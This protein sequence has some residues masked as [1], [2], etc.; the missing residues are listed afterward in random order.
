MLLAESHDFFADL[1]ESGIV[2]LSLHAAVDDAGHFAGIFFVEATSRDSGSTETDTGRIHRL[3]RI[4]RNRRTAAGDADLFH[5]H[6]SFLTGNTLRSHVHHDEVVVGAIADDLVAEL[7]HFGAHS[8]SVLDH[9]LG[10]GL[11]FRLQSFEEC[12]G[13]TGVDVVMRTTL[14]TREHALVDF[15][16]QRNFLEFALDHLLD[17]AV[18][19]HDDSRTRTTESLVGGG[20][21]D[22]EVRHRRI[23]CLTCDEASDVRNVSHGESA[24]FVGDFLE[25]LPVEVTAVGGETGEDHLRLFAESDF[26]DLVHVDATCF[27]VDFVLHE[28]VKHTGEV[29]R[30]AVRKVSTVVELEAEDLVTRLENGE[31]HSSVGRRTGKRLDIHV[32]ATKELLATFDSEGFHLVDDFV[33]TIVTLA[34]VAFTVLVGQHGAHGFHDGLGGVVFGS[35]ELDAVFLAFGFFLNDVVDFRICLLQCRFEHLATP[36]Y[37]V[38]PKYRIFYIVSVMPIILFVVFLASIAVFAQ[39]TPGAFKIDSIQYTIG[40]AF[41]DSRYH[42]KYDKWALDLLNWIHIETR[43]S[44]V[45]KLLLFNEGETVTETQIQEAERFLRKQNFLSDASINI[46]S[47]NGKNIANVKTSDNWTLAV[48]TTVGFS[49]NKWSYSNLNWGIGVQ[50][51]N[52]LGLGQLLGFYFGHDEFR[53]MW[54]VEYGAPHFLFRYNHLDLLY[55]YNTDGY[56]A[57]GKMYI[58]FLSRSQNQWA[59]TIEG[60]KNKHIAYFYGS[61]ELPPGA[62]V[63]DAQKKYKDSPIYNHK[64]ALLDSFQLYNGNDPVKLMAVKDFI[65]D[66]LSFRVSRSFGGTYRKLYAGAT[67][68]YHYTTASEGKLYPYAFTDGDTTYAIDSV[69]AVNEWLPER[70]DSRLGFYLTLSNIRYEKIKNFHNAK[71]TEDIEKGYELKAQIS[72]NYEQIGAADNDIRLDFWAN[73]MLGRD[74]HHLTLKSE[75]N[76]YLD[77]GE[78]HDYYGKISGEYIFHPTNTFATA[79]SGL[80]D[81]YEDARY[82]K[83]LTLGGVNGFAGFP[84]GFYAGQARVFA[85][86]EQRYF[87]NFEIATLMPVFVVFQ[88]IG[89]TAWDFWDINRKDLVYLTGFGL[90]FAQTKSISRLV[91]KMDVSIPLNGV[92]KGE[93][94]YSIITTY[95]L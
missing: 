7:L 13:L 23:D 69:T 27:L 92:R 14:H 29:H 52:F 72:K 86:L 11:E 74:M 68:D 64:K 93:P 76:F 5:G 71:W 67:Y 45:K 31:V 58:P 91:N 33:T 37:F 12:N 43:E 42:T 56:L 46:T 16:G 54:K 47:E 51:S 10:V 66:S 36:W 19:A 28:V 83:Q 80:A 60:I 62:T 38:P 77:H 22:V 2:V 9:V 30:M 49:G 17:G 95:S 34:H 44:T 4:E 25:A 88:S 24:H 59:Y 48:P 50:E 53:D 1:G 87:T 65:D 75:M 73:L 41:D 94:H 39:D 79:L 81:F 90:R 18:L 21:H 70:K 84:T 82:G 8:L 63:Y 89:E 55:S 6:F 57:Y 3:A 26:A 20:G 85:N 15:L 35:D 61:G 32:V 78:K 40:D